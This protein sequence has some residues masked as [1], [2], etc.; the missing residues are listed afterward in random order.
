M[1]Q[2]LSQHAGV[3]LGKENFWRTAQGAPFLLANN[4]F[5]AFQGR[6]C[7]LP[8]C[9][10]FDP[11]AAIIRP[12]A[13]DPVFR[14]NYDDNPLFQTA[15]TLARAG[16]APL[17]IAKGASRAA[18]DTVTG[19]YELGVN[20]AGTAAYQQLAQHGATEQAEYYFGEHRQAAVAAGRGLLQLG[21][22]AGSLLTG[23]TGDAQYEL[24]AQA[25]E[26][27][28]GGE[29]TW[30]ERLG[31]GGF[32]VAGFFVGGAEANVAVKAR[33]AA[34]VTAINAAKNAERG[35]MAAEKLGQTAAT[36]ASQAAQGLPAKV[37]SPTACEKLA[38]SKS[39]AESATQSYLPYRRGVNY[40]LESFENHVGAA[41]VAAESA[42]LKLRLQFEEGMD[43]R[44]FNRKAEALRRNIAE[45]TAVSNVP[46]GVS[47]AARRSVTRQYR[48]D[49]VRRIDSFYANNAAARESALAK[50]R[51]SDIDHILDLQLGGRNAR[52]NLKTLESFTNQRLGSQ[53]TEQLPIG[54]SI[55]ITDLEVFY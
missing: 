15:E 2:S 40:S 33:Q 21:G 5:V 23:T 4:P 11:E 22:A 51:A 24:L 10:S 26:G 3:N 43:L 31:Y 8:E 36:K 34:R 12:G 13:R 38:A 16:L 14:Y 54:E 7:Q 48:R 20:L 27:F 45:G 39:A 37:L 30:E 55:P 46:H 17:A 44:A 41:P 9:L 29:G 49:L 25:G 28:V 6:Q 35:A 18:A 52:G 1:I 19:T 32:N 50:L 42:G 53:I 47:D